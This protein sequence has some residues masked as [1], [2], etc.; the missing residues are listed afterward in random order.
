MKDRLGV[1]D[2]LDMD[3]RLN[4]L[5]RN[6]RKVIEAKH[7]IISTHSVKWGSQSGQRIHLNS[8]MP[9]KIKQVRSFK[10]AVQVFKTEESNL[11][12]DQI[13]RELRGTPGYD[14]IGLPVDEL[15]SLYCNA[16]YEHAFWPSVSTD[17]RGVLAEI[18]LDRRAEYHS[19]W[20]LYK[21]GHYP[22][23]YFSRSVIYIY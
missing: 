11:I 13:D 4:D 5:T 16:E 20:Y 7:F 8:R 18:L 2:L 12:E 3:R 1:E 21:K 19:R 15:A 9:W 10:K 14:E 22:C 17:I 23:G 6:K